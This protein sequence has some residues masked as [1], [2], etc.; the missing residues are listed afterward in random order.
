MNDKSKV[1]PRPLRPDTTIV[2][3]GREPM[4]YHGFVNPPVYHASTVL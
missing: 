3:G 4:S 1:P 2:T